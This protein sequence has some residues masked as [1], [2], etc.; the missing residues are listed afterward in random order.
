MKNHKKLFFHKNSEKDLFSIKALKG[1]LKI[2]VLFLRT[3][4]LFFVIF[5][6]Q[7]QVLGNLELFIH[8]EMDGRFGS[9][10][11]WSQLPALFTFPI[12]STEKSYSIRYQYRNLKKL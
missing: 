4:I 2:Y 6:R 9:C 7:N 5:I 1:T 8:L 11:T 3:I 12:V 10:G